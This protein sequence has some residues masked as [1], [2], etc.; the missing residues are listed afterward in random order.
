MLFL[1]SKCNLGMGELVKQ[2]YGLWMFKM[3]GVFVKFKFLCGIVF[4]PFGHIEE[5]CLE[6]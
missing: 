6:W 1:W 2:I 5:C 3:M 4:D